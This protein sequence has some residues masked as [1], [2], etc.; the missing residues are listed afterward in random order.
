[1]SR[2][3]EA[4]F[5]AFRNCKLSPINTNAK[6]SEIKAW[7]GDVVTKNCFK[8]LFKKIDPAKSETYMSKI[9]ENLWKGGKKNG[10]KMQIAFAISVCEIVL[11]PD[12]PFVSINED[13]IKPVLTKNLVSF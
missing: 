7:K 12:N 6:E 4:M 1:M 9:L 2:I 11:N 5:S 3:R 13:I 10:S 8:Q